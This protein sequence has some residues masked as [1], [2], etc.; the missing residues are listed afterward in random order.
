MTTKDMLPI[1]KELDKVGYHSLEVW[2]GAT[3]DACLRFLNEDPWDRLRELR[4]AIPNTKLQMLL[5]GQN[6]LGYRHYPDD[7]VEEFVK[8]AIGNGIDIIRIFDALNDERNLMT[9]ISATRKYGGHA[10]CAISYTTSPVHN[11]EYYVNKA[12]SYENAGADSI[13]IK[14][15]AGILLPYDAEKLVKSIKKNTDLEVQVHSHFTSGIANQMYMKAVEAGADV[16]DTALSPFG[17]GSSQPATEAMVAS[18]HN[19]PYDTGL[20]LNKLNEIADYFRK[21]RQKAED[22]GQ[23]NQKVLG[24]NIKTLLYQ[25]PGGMLSNLVSQLK[26]QGKLDKLEDVLEEVPRVRKDLG[27]P[28]LV[29]PMSQMVG[30]QAVF[31]I[32]MGERYKVIPNEIKNY[33]KGLYGRPTTDMDSEFIK[34]IVGNEKIYTG[35][36]ADLLEPQLDEFREAIKEY[37][38]Q[39]ED[40]LSYALFPQVAEKFFKERKVKKYQ[41]D[42]VMLYLDDDDE[43][44]PV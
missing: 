25:V 29:T 1:A 31:N 5:R 11:I 38:E 34:R 8:R 7:V 26:D 14:D 18:L 30:T 44:Y 20:D 39:D 33:V 16:I 24:I 19:S 12:K 37:I 2:G 10:Q 17:N 41:V 21:I 40:V 36:P 23:I 4:K 9:A 32:I 6:I 42:E 15:M 3:F 35:R 28:P 13:C 43:T 22:S 27:Y